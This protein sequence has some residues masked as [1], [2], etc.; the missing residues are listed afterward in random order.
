MKSFC[1]RNDLSIV[2]ALQFTWFLIYDENVWWLS[3]FSY[4]ISCT[5]ISSKSFAAN[6]LCFNQYG[7][8]IKSRTNVAAVVD[9]LFYLRIITL[10]TRSNKLLKIIVSKCDQP[11]MICSGA[12][13]FIRSI[14]DWKYIWV[15]ICRSNVMSIF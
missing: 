5:N 13:Q 3:C 11:K 14:L 4:F 1:Y 7:I 12:T 15:S 8:I 10:Q 2:D 9:Y 6:R